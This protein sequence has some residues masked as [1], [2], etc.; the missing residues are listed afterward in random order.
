MEKR[1]TGLK[2]K[3]L[4]PLVFSLA[5]APSLNNGS[6]LSLN[7]RN[8]KNKSYLENIA[9][10]EAFEQRNYLDSIASAPKYPTP[11]GECSGYVREVGRDFYGK[12]YFFADAWD[13][14]NLDKLI[15]SF[16]EKENTFEKIKALEKEGI[17]NKGMVLGVYHRP[18][19]SSEK[20]IYGKNA[21]YSH[22]IIFRGI[23]RET[24]EF[25]FDHEW[26]KKQDT[27]SLSFIKQK[28]WKIVDLLD[29][30]PESYAEAISKETNHPSS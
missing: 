4:M 3:L 26:G 19:K 27:I 7:Y 18:P 8:E 21:K 15:Y 30:N 28:N 29:E 24:G 5:V 1:I 17:L 23:D 11:G 10:K 14:R 20:D 12:N 16:S 6:S 9:L 2:R 13:R 22:V 25:Y